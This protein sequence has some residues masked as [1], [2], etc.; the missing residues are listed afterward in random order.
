[1]KRRA[2]IYVFYST[3]FTGSLHPLGHRSV[4][5]HY[6]AHH[7]QFPHIV[8]AL[9]RLAPT[10]LPSVLPPGACGAIARLNFDGGRASSFPGRGCPDAI[11]AES[12]QTLAWEARVPRVACLLFFSQYQ[13]DDHPF[14]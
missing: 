11:A 12:Y 2:C 14:D 7:S 13:L 4:H 9:S 3:T 10:R 8:S 6:L 1:M 5:C